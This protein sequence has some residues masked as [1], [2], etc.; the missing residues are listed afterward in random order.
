MLDDLVPPVPAPT[1]D[2]DT[3]AL[4]HPLHPRRHV[5][6]APRAPSLP[7]RQVCRDSCLYFQR[8]LLQFLKTE[9]TVL[10]FY[11]ILKCFDIKLTE[12]KNLWTHH[13]DLK[14]FKGV[15]C[16]EI[17]FRKS[18]LIVYFLVRCVV[19]AKIKKI[20]CFK[21]DSKKLTFARRARCCTRTG[22]QWRNRG[23]Q[24]A[25]EEIMR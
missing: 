24:I 12:T 22:T 3:L 1:P 18:M 8:I 20:I 16:G 13:F 21:K 15:N 4:L 17:Y 19:T 10:I 5:A 6:A 25:A 7:P 23:L 9:I 2:E 14:K 11:C